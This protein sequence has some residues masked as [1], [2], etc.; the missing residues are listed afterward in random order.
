MT[1]AWNTEMAR[2][3][4]T[5]GHSTRLERLLTSLPSVPS[6]HG[7]RCPNPSPRLNRPERL[8]IWRRIFRIT[9]H[10]S[11]RCDC[12]ASTT[13]EMANSRRLIGKHWMANDPHG[14]FC[15][16]LAST[17]ALLSVHQ[18]MSWL[19]FDRVAGNSLIEISQKLCRHR[20]QPK[21]H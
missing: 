10:Q 18:C 13:R 9:S 15:H 17:S 8:A 19:I 7:C 2:H 14:L 5:R 4:P 6:N 21:V 16:A 3:E 20:S 11:K 1:S 12:C